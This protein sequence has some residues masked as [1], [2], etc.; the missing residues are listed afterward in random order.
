MPE[1]PIFADRSGDQAGPQAMALMH[2]AMDWQAGGGTAPP[3]DVL[4][5]KEGF[6]LTAT[7]FR[8]VTAGGVRFSYQLGGRVQAVLPNGASRDELQL[9]L[10]GTVFGAVAWLNGLVPLH[11]SAVA[12]ASGAVAF[13]GPQG[14]GKSTLVAALSKAG[15]AHI[16]DDTLVAVPCADGPLALPDGK[17]IK[18]WDDALELVGLQSQAAIT[19][20]PGKYYAEVLSPA[21]HALPLRHLIFLED[22]PDIVIEPITGTAKLELLPAAL[23]RDFIYAA[24]ADQSAHEAMM[25]T[26]AQHVRFWRLQRPRDA[27]RFDDDIQEIIG[28]IKG[29]PQ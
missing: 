28:L 25:L 26:F 11:A 12:H 1:L 29:L 27:F 14:A 3:G 20:V 8:F 19:S 4:F 23:Y 22:G 2:H 6:T 21:R 16:C 18:L 13:T 10:W 24:H 7:S 17:P 15:M 5:D 9:F